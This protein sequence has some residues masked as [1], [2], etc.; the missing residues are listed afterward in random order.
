M[1]S[2]KAITKLLEIY[3]KTHV[4]LVSSGIEF[5]PE[6]I[7]AAGGT[8]IYF[9]YPESYDKS[10]RN[11]DSDIPYLENETGLFGDPRTVSSD[12]VKRY[13][14]FTA[15]LSQAKD[16]DCDEDL[17]EVI[18]RYKEFMDVLHHFTFLAKVR[19]GDVL[20]YDKASSEADKAEKEF[21]EN[22]KTKIE[23]IENGEEFM[24][25]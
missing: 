8:R 20:T 19:N 23:Q 22:M 7:S 12:I 13:F 3:L 24:E 5:D 25:V 2:D 1:I 21:L 10:C 9:T 6:L 14:F 15:L 18:D 11:L 4:A 17:E 16:F